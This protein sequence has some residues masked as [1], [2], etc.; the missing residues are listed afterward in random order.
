MNTAFRRYSSLDLETGSIGVLSQVQLTVSKAVL[1]V[2]ALLSSILFRGAWVTD[3]NVHR[4]SQCLSPIEFAENYE[5]FH[6]SCF[7]HLHLSSV[8]MTDADHQ[9]LHVLGAFESHLPLDIS[10]MPLSPGRNLPELQS[11]LA[12]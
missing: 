1:I 6:A 7:H 8:D 11:P 10:A 5:H 2:T 9:L 4:A 3:Q 12:S